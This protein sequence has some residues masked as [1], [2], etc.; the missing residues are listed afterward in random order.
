MTNKTSPEECDI[1]P[2]CPVRLQDLTRQGQWP[3]QSTHEPDFSHTIA[4]M[5]IKINDGRE[6]DK[7]GEKLRTEDAGRL[8]LVQ[9][10]RWPVACQGTADFQHTVSG[11]S[12]KPH[13]LTTYLQVSLLCLLYY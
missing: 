1:V 11:R 3:S 10:R 4:G 9:Q 6:G 12:I 13:P 8:M 5:S 7:K 2:K